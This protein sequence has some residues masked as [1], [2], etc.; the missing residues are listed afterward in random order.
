MTLYTLIFGHGSI[1]L[2]CQI[3]IM[4]YSVVGSE[5]TNSMCKTDTSDLHTNTTVNKARATAE[6]AP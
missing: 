5:S 2:P 6:T 1:I 3:F 4:N